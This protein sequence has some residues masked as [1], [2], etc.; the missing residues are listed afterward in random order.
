[1]KDHDKALYDQLLPLHE[2]D[3]FDELLNKLTPNETNPQRLLIKIEIRRLM[4]PC[5]KP[6]DLRGKVAGNCRPYFLHGANH[7]MD[8]V[9]I[10][11][12]HRRIDIYQGR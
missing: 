12:Y 10:N 1:M 2:K 3:G 8:D 9:A 5:G 7:W 4:S 6:V 11:L